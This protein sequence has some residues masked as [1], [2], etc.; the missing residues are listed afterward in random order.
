MLA[1]PPTE[2]SPPTRPKEVVEVGVG[3][4][5]ADVVAPLTDTAVVLEGETNA[6]LLL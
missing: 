1:A 6:Y 5:A 3:T 4:K 2:A